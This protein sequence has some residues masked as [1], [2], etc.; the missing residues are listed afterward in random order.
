[1]LVAAKI[2]LPLDLFLVG[3]NVGRNDSVTDKA[4]VVSDEGEDSL[5]SECF[6]RV[7]VARLNWLDRY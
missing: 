7:C 1:M 6:I 4:G 2:N 3:T 5:M